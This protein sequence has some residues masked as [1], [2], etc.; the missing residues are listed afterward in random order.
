MK[1]ITF[2]LSSL[3]LL[4]LG[5]KEVKTDANDWSLQDDIPSGFSAFSGSSSFDP[6]RITIIDS[7]LTR[8]I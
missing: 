6:N 5:C 3:L 4:L 1:Q 8:Y 7:A 2:I